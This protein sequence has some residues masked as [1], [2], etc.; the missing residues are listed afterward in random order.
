MQGK[1]KK[2]TTK[3]VSFGKALEC[4]LDQAWKVC[5]GQNYLITKINQ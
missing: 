4:L 3:A 5:Q 1:N 2:K